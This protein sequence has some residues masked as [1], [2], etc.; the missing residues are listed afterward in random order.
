MAGPLARLLRDGRLH[1]ADGAWGSNLIA[2][3]LDL[4]TDCADHW[5]LIR[6]DAVTELVEAFVG[7]GAEII[8]SN[9]FGGNRMRLTSA[10]L[11]SRVVD[12]NR[13]GIVLA[14]E[15]MGP[16]R[17]IAASMGPTGIKEIGRYAVEIG[18]AYAEQ[19]TVLADVGADFLLLET[20]TSPEE[21]RIAVDSVKE[22]TALEVVCSFAFTREVG[23][24]FTTWSG[25]SVGEAVLA[26][27]ESG[28]AMVGANCCA[29]D[30]GLSE[31]LAAL[32]D[33][34][35]ALPLWLKPNAGYPNV[36][37]GHAVYP[38]P[39]AALPLPFGT[40]ADGNVAVI[41]GCCGTTP[42]H[43]KTLAKSVVAWNGTGKNLHR[44]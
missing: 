23:E 22:A 17:L 8:T 33:A 5:N 34:A 3:G 31:L 41:G 13:R 24:G 2:A 21:A 9:T 29:A 25:A 35:R 36:Q 12:I 42:E 6:P 39:V 27:R 4:A 26:V 44:A 19:A 28:V 18:R 32:H 40:L 10:G 43:L 30:D 11:E 16:T 37:K 1:L 38:T 7:A 15:A 14:R 20:M